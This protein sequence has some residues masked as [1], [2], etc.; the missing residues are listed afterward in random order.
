M[1]LQLWRTREKYIKLLP[2]THSAE[3][4]Y[5]L[6]IMV[7]LVQ[8]LEKVRSLQWWLWWSFTLQLIFA[9]SCS[10]SVF[11]CFRHPPLEESSWCPL[12]RGFR[13]DRVRGRKKHAN[14]TVEGGKSMGGA[15]PLTRR[16]T[17]DLST[18][19]AHLVRSKCSR[20]FSWWN[21]DIPKVIAPFD[22]V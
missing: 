12:Y 5:S 9:G 4:D 18:L 11:L 6:F 14:R 10:V 1:V 8:M 13:L 21:I 19:R 20:R 16:A 17:M 2:Q 22:F 7:M 3:V 15:S